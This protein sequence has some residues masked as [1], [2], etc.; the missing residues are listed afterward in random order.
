MKMNSPQIETT[1][2]ALD[3]VRIPLDRVKR[4]VR[5]VIG[6]STPKLVIEHDP[7]A[8]LTKSSHPNSQVVRTSWPSM[9]T[10]QSSL[11]RLPEAFEENPVTHDLHKT[12]PIPVFE[13]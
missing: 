8:D 9:E 13:L 5:G 7:I 1:S 3:F 10:E 4:L 12:L 6:F 2:Y 11:C